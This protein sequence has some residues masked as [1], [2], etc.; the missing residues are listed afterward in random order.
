MKIFYLTVRERRPSRVH[1]LREQ[2]RG[3]QLVADDDGGCE[4]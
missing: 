1:L 2:V 4:T 3:V